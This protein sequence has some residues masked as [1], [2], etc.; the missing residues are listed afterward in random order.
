MIYER[1]AKGTV[2]S[3]C[4]KILDAAAANKFGVISTIDMK[5]KMKSKGVPFDSQC[6]IIEV[7]NPLQAKKVLEANM[8]ISTILPCRISVYQQ[9]GKVKVAALKPTA[10]LRIF[11]NP[12]L[13]PVAKEVE[14]TIIRI[15]NTACT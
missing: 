4:K 12:E 6:F 1:Q 5:E 9:A 3:V 7:C 11:D 2:D 10:V 14:D 13:Q 15:I 8:S